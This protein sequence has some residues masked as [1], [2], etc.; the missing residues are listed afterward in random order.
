[1]IFS[2]ALPTNGLSIAM[3]GDFPDELRK[4]MSTCR[5]GNGCLF[6]IIEPNVA[7]DA[8]IEYCF[9]DG[10]LDKSHIIRVIWSATLHVNECRW[11]SVTAST[12]GADRLSRSAIGS[13]LTTRPL[14]IATTHLPRW[15]TT[16]AADKHCRVVLQ[17]L[18]PG[19]PGSY[20]SLLQFLGIEYAKFVTPY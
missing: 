18:S 19:G 11:K 1:M 13:W 9:P 7:A 15:G 14:V 20:E 12:E 2:L 5:P 17:C 3:S 10:Y 6:H 8:N 4:V 16:W